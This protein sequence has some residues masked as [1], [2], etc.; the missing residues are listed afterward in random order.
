M[1]PTPFADDLREFLRSL[2]RHEVEYL[3][4]GGYAVTL[5]GFP[6]N[7]ADL[8]IWIRPTPGNADRVIAALEAFGFAPGSG[9][10]RSASSSRRAERGPSRCASASSK[11]AAERLER[12]ALPEVKTGARAAPPAVRR[13]RPFVAR[14]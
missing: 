3:L 10:R 1:E 14:A 13:R 7:T 5:H 9:I 4:V 2:G 6:R 8:D 11:R 12:R